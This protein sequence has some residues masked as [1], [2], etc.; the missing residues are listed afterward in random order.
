MLNAFNYLRSE[1]SVDL[2]ALGL[3][4]IALGL[5]FVADVCMRWSDL[6]M[7]YTDDGIFPREMLTDPESA[8]YHYWNPSLFLLSGSAL[9]ANV[10]FAAG[11]FVGV[12]VVL[13]YRTRLFTLLA[14]LWLLSVQIR[15]PLILQAGDDYLRL[16]FL[17][18]IFLPWGVRYSLDAF[19]TKAREHDHFDLSVFAVLIQVGA[20]YLCTALMK[21][22]PEW[23]SG[24]DALYYAL[25]LD[26]MVKPLGIAIYANGGFLAAMTRA[27]LVLEYLVPILI[28][29]PWQNKFFRLI[30]FMGLL[31][32]H[33]GIELTMHVGLFSWICVSAA[34]T[35]LPATSIKLV[36][37]G[38]RFVKRFFLH[39]KY[40]LPYHN[41]VSVKK[42]PVA[43]KFL[44]VVL[45]SIGVLKNMDSLGMPFGKMESAVE[46]VSRG[47]GLHQHW[48]MFA[49][50]VYKDDGWYIYEATTEEGKIDLLTG[51]EVSE[52]KPERIFKRYG[53]ARK[54]K[55]GEN[56]RFEWNSG[57]RK[58]LCEYLIQSWNAEHQ[59][60]QVEELSVVYM[61]ERTLPNYQ[62]SP[63]RRQE[64][65]QCNCDD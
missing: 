19:E 29:M 15:N 33:L 27:S 45:A 16:M 28:F 25:S 58:P 56:L 41:P 49:P 52:G 54:R 8:F 11:L 9:W 43:I 24:S 7:F 5:V 35:L 50:S 6:S 42:P 55:L 10:L 4:R 39:V 59:K 47:I 13:G 14:F 22:S 64:L 3:T 23:H 18:G 2:R 53:S 38:F 30:V 62:E 1:W 65:V 61:L 12:M 63:I 32:F 51:R 46:Q 31:L 36:E 44:I 20:L 21:S 60:K 40:S 37:K 34:L 57:A 48:G 26:Q 17:W